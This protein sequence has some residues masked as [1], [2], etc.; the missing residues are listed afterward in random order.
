MNRTQT[1]QNSRAA[2]RATADEIRANNT[3]DR[4]PDD[5]DDEIPFPPRAARRALAK[6]ERV[7]YSESLI[8]ERRGR[9]DAPPEKT[10]RAKRVR[11]RRKA[12]RAAQR[13][14]R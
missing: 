1:R 13:E 10:A 3:L 5:W 2:A 6:L 12:E 7:G 4:A 11:Q 8:T 9:S 14:S